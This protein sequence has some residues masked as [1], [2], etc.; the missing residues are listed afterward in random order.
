[1]ILCLDNHKIEACHLILDVVTDIG[2]PGLVGDQKPLSRED[3]SLLQ[4]INGRGM[5]E[6]IWERCLHV[7][8]YVLLRESVNMELVYFMMD[9]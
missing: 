9:L 1:M 4:Q 7:G 6:F 8:G 2:V 5:V 3:G